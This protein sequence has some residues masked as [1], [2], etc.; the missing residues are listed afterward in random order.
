[1]LTVLG[2]SAEFRWGPVAGINISELYW[3]QDLVKTSV[4]PGPN[5]GVMGE[6]MIPGIGFGVD[7]ALKYAMHGAQV[8]FG[9]RPIWGSEGYGNEKVWFQTL[10]LPVNLRFKWTRMDGLERTIAPFAYVGPVFSFNLVTS[11]L[12]IIEH[13][14]GSVGLQFGI[15]G[16]L[17]ERFQVSAGY[18]WGLSYDIRTLKLDNFSGRT[19]GWQINF[20][21]LF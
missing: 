7:F 15:G 17:F 1:M 14:A 11:D 16:E 9:S 4:L 21:W 13:P 19:R 2:A 12:P 5:V 8:D 18:M 20:A 6:I 3:K 10:Q